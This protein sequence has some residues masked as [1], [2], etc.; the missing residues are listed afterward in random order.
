[1]DKHLAVIDL[2]TNT[3]HLIIV[4]VSADQSFRQV[5]R[6]RILVSLAE[7]C[8]DKICSSAFKRGIKALN[9]FSQKLYTYK[10]NNYRAIGTAALRT[11]SNGLEFIAAAKNATG[12]TIELV[13]GEQ[14]AKLIYQGVQQAITIEAPVLIMD[15]GG[16]SVELILADNKGIIAAQSFPIGIAVLFNNFIHSDPVTREEIENIRAFIIHNTSLFFQKNHPC[17]PLKSLIGAAGTFE[18]LNQILECHYHSPVAITTF[19]QLLKEIIKTTHQQRLLSPNI[20]NSRAKMIVGALLLT[21]I[22]SQQAGIEKILISPYALKEGAIS[23]MIK[24]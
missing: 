10:V 9:H 3:F 18:I 24:K 6:E 4:K 17:L 5:Y 22:I 14:E 8:I 16:G 20:P 12:I 21:D 23:Q 13:D 7:E 19:H 11:A 15:I 2:G 1:M